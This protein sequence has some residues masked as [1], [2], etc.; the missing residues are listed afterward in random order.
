MVSKGS[1]I[2]LVLTVNNVTQMD[3]TMDIFYTFLLL[4][5]ILFFHL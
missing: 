5:S 4:M 3:R 2:V 1:H